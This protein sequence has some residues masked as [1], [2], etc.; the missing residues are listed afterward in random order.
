L[1]A[2][3]TNILVYAHR[4]DSEWHEQ[5]SACIRQLAEGDA[6][7]A[8]AWPCL[9]EFYAIVTHS[10]IYNPPSSHEQ[11][12]AQI[13]A[14]L[15]AP[16]LVAWAETGAYWAALKEI[17]TAGRITGPHVHDARVAAICLAHGAKELWTAD[18]D[19]SRF[20]KLRTRNPL[21]G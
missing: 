6:P 20:G 16:G 13:D 12:V 3:D 5:A 19:F 15:D 7:W 8:I 17:L 10:R 14:W 4:S 1:I 9:H 2:V 18:R 21:V 11:A